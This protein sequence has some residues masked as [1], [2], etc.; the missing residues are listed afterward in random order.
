MVR[1]WRRSCTGTFED[2]RSSPFAG[3]SRVRRQQGSPHRVPRPASRARRITRTG[4]CV[5]DKLATGW[6]LPRPGTPKGEARSWTPVAFLLGLL[7]RLLRLH[8]VEN[9]LLT[10]Y[11]SRA[12]GDVGSQRAQVGIAAVDMVE[13][14]PRWSSRTSLSLAL[15]EPVKGVGLPLGTVCT[16]RLR[17]CGKHSGATVGRLDLAFG[18][19]PCWT[20]RTATS[21]PCSSEGRSA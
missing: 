9:G 3:P 1:P 18:Y 16:S 4:A 15:T 19:G 14:D 10:V 6:Y 13:R 17:E 11:T 5:S 8:G 2:R 7:R 21:S 12:T 20:S